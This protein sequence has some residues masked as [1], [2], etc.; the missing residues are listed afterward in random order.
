[1]N[2]NKRQALEPPKTGKEL[3]DIYFLDARSHLLETAA[4]LDRL[5]LADAGG[6]ARLATIRRLGE[7]VADDER[8]K[9][10]RI[11]NELSEGA[12]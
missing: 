11:L 3:L 7:I 10:V 1:M 12:E 2:S 8:D 9:V 5:E 6:D 4:L